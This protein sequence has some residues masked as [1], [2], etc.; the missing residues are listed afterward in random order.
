M[1]IQQLAEKVKGELSGYELSGY[2]EICAPVYKRTLNCLMASKGQLPIVTEFLLHYYSLGINLNEITKILGI[3]QEL[4]MD[5]WWELIH[6]DFIDFVTK[7]ITDIGYGY[8][9]ERKLEKVEHI[10]VP[11]C[12]DGLIGT[13]RMDNSQLMRNKNVRE[14]GLRSMRPVISDI[15]ENNIDFQQVKYVIN[16]YKKIDEEYYEGD[17]LDVSK[18][19]GIKTFYKRLHVILYSNSDYHTRVAVYD[20]GERVDDYEQALIALENKGDCIL[21]PIPDTFP[22]VDIIS[23]LDLKSDELGPGS[24]FNCWLDLIK[25]SKI[26]VL[27]S[28]P[29]IQLCSPDDIWIDL[30][31][32]A[33]KRGVKVTFIST[34]REFIS[35]YQKEQYAKLLSIN[36]LQVIQVPQS[37]NKFIIVDD[38]DGVISDFERHKVY[39]ANTQE[40]YVEAG[41]SLDQTSIESI[42]VDFVNPEMEIVNTLTPK[43]V[44][45]QWLDTKIKNITKLVNEFDDKLKLRNQIGWLGDYPIPHISNVYSSPLAVNENKFKEFI[46]TVNQ[47]FS[48]SVDFTG[49]R[50]GVKR[51]FWGDFKS[52]CPNVQ[53]VLHK[54]RMYRNFANH[55]E[56]DADYKPIFY[57]YLDEDLLGRLPQFVKDGYLMLQIKLLEDLE[58]ELRS[59][60][61]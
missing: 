10:S 13:V 25:K 53:R 17:L 31:S 9:E 48:E 2:V 50:A 39:L 46:N 42:W 4:V 28:L 12:I 55:L 1:I 59:G 34:G 7:K 58:D 51:Y 5:S 24:I 56:I 41:Y 8:L 47:A 23:K 14:N 22:V 3:D 60:V 54:I 26:K 16:S 43:I 18:V 44:D 37:W 11:V 15:N 32:D 21:K 6:R 61:N 19:E 45:K 30:I 35:G 27:I 33:L 52:L 38:K 20:G 36:N 40:G 57:Q 29:M 49:K